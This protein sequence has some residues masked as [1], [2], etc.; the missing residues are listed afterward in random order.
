MRGGEREPRQEN[1]HSRR[2]SSNS[3]RLPN[4]E[5]ISCLGPETGPAAPLV[6]L[7]VP[8]VTIKMKRESAL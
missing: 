4:H 8:A 5:W 3:S 7:G 6:S 1:Q 2:Y